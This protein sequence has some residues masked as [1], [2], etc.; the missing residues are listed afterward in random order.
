MTTTV[1][2]LHEALGPNRH[3]DHHKRGISQLYLPS[4]CRRSPVRP[5]GDSIEEQTR[6]YNQTLQRAFSHW[7]IV[8]NEG[9]RRS[10]NCKDQVKRIVEKVRDR[11]A[12]SEAAA[13]SIRAS[14][15]LNLVTHQAKT[16]QGIIDLAIT[17]KKKE[18]T[19]KKKETTSL[20]SRL[21]G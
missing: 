19:F 4:V 12:F 11:L 14:L 21:T 3:F 10:Q 15:V 5:A 17:F 6:H 7:T 8:V 2:S 18:I 13:P 1:G 16:L 20:V 9:Q